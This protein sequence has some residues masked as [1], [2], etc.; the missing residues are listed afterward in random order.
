M[1]S[2]NQKQ[3]FKRIYFFK[4]ATKIVFVKLF[5]L[6]I[7]VKATIIL[8]MHLIYVTNLLKKH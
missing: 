4:I 7:T 6:I 3:V 8:D 5:F 2:F 1:Y